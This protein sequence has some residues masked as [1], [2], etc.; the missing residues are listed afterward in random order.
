MSCV[1]EKEG[2]GIGKCLHF[3]IFQLPKAEQ[4][5]FL[6]WVNYNCKLLNEIKDLILV[7]SGFL[8]PTSK[9]VA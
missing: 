2:K 3:F 1:Q 8:P 6:R 9:L 4:R 7:R 5:P